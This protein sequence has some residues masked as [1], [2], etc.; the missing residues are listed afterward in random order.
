VKIGLDQFPPRRMS[1]EDKR[2]LE[3]AC[4]TGKL[5]DG[6]AAEAK[7]GGALKLGSVDHKKRWTDY[8]QRVLDGACTT[9]K[10][11][12]GRGASQN[13]LARYLGFS[14]QTIII[15]LKGRQLPRHFEAMSEGAIHSGSV[16]RIA[17]YGKHLAR[18][19]DKM[20][21]YSARPLSRFG[22]KPRREQAG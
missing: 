8:D 21:R 4:T 5:P 19:L 14:R 10:L 15:R 16:R 20:R 1:E 17:G 18:A 2:V 11:P 12:D 6:R 3:E 13:R 9:G 7:R 22:R